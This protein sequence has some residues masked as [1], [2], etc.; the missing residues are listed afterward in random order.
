MAR[1]ADS[2]T[3]HPLWKEKGLKIIYRLLGSV[4]VFLGRKGKD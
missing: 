3:R 4:K 1:A 2:A